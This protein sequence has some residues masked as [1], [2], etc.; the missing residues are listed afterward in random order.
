MIRSI[1]IAIERPLVSCHASSICE[2]PEGELLAC[3]YAGEVEAEGFPGQVILGTRYDAPSRMWSPARVWVDVPGRACGNP[4]IFPSPDGREV[5]LIA[6]VNYGEWCSGGTRLF[7]KRSRDGGRSWSDLELLLEE[8]GILGKNKPLIM[9]SRIILPV[10]WE[11]RWSAAFL[12]GDGSDWR[13]VGDLGRE[14]GARI[15]QPSLVRLG[16]GTILAYMRT[17]EN[18]I[19]ESRSRDGGNT[20]ST[21]RPTAL[22]N[23]NSGID[24][25]RLRSG[26]LVLAHNPTSL[27]STPEKRDPGL[28]D[29]MPVGFDTWGARTPLVISVSADESRSWAVRLT[30][31]AGPGAFSYPAVIQARDGAIHVSYT[32]NRGSIRHV[33]I[34][35]DELA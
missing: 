9:D 25:A 5:W 24:L 33:R 10:E 26:R 12:L 8:K 14:A 35:E 20:W 4:R 30:L 3:C 21:A 31:E 16:D 17:Q 28:P 13:L 18:Y 32:H 2:S 19:Y 29:K 7:M 6:P 15:I 27:D 34:E 1:C 23:N 22:S 11:A